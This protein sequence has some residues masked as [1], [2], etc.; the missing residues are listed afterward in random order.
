MRYNHKI[1][2]RRQLLN[3]VKFHRLMLAFQIL[4][5]VLFAALAVVII[6]TSSTMRDL[7][8]VCLSVCLLC[9]DD[10]GSCRSGAHV[11]STLKRRSHFARIC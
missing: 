8:M 7:H 10:P 6:G 1:T 4:N 9:L 11:F 2:S 5:L 3:P